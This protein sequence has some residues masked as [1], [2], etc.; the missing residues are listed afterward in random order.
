MNSLLQ[1]IKRIHT[2]IL[3]VFFLF[4]TSYFSFA[5][6]IHFSH[7]NRQPLYQ[8]P[9]NTGLFDGDYRFF[10][11][12]KDQWRN[13]SVPFT[14]YNFGIDRR[15]GK[16]GLNYGGFFFYDQVGDGKLQ[17]IELLTSAS[18]FFDLKQDSSLFLSAGLQLG[19]NY[20]ALNFSK[21]YFDN[22]FNGLFFDPSLAT[23][24]VFANAQKSNISIGT[25]AVLS[26][27]RSKKQS[28]QA[29]ISFHNLNRPNQGFFGTKI[30]R[31]IRVSNFINGIYKINDEWSVLPGLG[32]NFQGKYR[33]LLVGSQVQYILENQFG[34][35]KAVDA[36][37]WFRS[38]DA[39][40]TRVGYSHQSWTFALSYD[41]NISTLTPASRLRGGLELSIHYIFKKIPFIPCRLKR[42][43]EFI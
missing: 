13:V 21:F 8:N 34:V 9:A 43:P 39:I 22:Q 33:E 17:T 6:D 15:E 12:Y 19:W 23:G 25:G 20:R 24:E 7:L 28:Y 2:F 3:S 29:G 11:N 18:K 35:F 42:C 10:A 41:T 1:M 32:L 36:G 40:I 38:K 14:T 5:Q 4:A 30:N 27:I 37:I 31:D 26:W 16:F